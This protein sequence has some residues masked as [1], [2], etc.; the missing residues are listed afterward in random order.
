MKKSAFLT[1]FFC[2]SHSYAQDIE[3]IKKLDTVYIK[4]KKSVNQ[5]KQGSAD[6]RFYTIMLDKIQDEGSLYF[7]K[8]DFKDNSKE[9]AKKYSLRVEKKSFL[10]KHKNDIVGIDFFQKYGI[11]KS[12][13]D[14]FSANSVI[15]IID[16]DERKK[17]KIALYRVS[18][19]SSYR[20]GE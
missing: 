15:Y 9:T 17:E 6:Y 12:T 19:S 16:Y 2:Y 5:T 14:A 18:M 8:P 4:F 3:Y 1:I 10:K 7:T 20:L 11:K 13:Y